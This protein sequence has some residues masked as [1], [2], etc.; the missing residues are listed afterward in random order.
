M[1]QKST[2][3]KGGE[4]MLEKWAFDVDTER[5]RRGLK[6]YEVAK[7]AGYSRQHLTKV[8]TG[9]VKSEKLKQQLCR[10]YGVKTI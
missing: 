3:F 10:E 6:V 1:R 9:K 5:R 7:K 8:M 4:I 2:N